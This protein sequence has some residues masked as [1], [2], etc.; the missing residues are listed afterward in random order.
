MPK[1]K[2]VHDRETPVQNVAIKE[3]KLD[4]PNNTP[5]K[6]V[7]KCVQFKITSFFKNPQVINKPTQSNNTETTEKVKNNSWKLGT[8]NV[9]NQ[10]KLYKGEIELVLLNEIKIDILALQEVGINKEDTKNKHL[11]IK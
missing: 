8:L 4:Q 2:K 5:I 11:K 1:N 10:Y 9:N 6:Q 7:N 3:L